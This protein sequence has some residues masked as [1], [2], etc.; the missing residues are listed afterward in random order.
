MKKLNFYFATLLVALLAFS[1]T[2][3]DNPDIPQVEKG[4]RSVEL[5]I[6]RSSTKADDVSVPA[7]TK[8]PIADGAI[9]F[10][11]VDGKCVKMYKLTATD[12]SNLAGNSPT[13]VLIDQVPASASSALLLTNYE[14]ATYTYPTATGQ[15]IT[16]IKALP[17]LVQNQQPKTGNMMVNNVIMSGVA[18]IE[19]NSNPNP[20]PPDALYKIAMTITPI[21]SRLEVSRV[22]VEGNGNQ[23]GDITEFRLR[24]IFIPNFYPASTV[25]GNAVTPPLVYPYN[26]VTY[27]TASFPFTTGTGFLNDYVASTAPHPGLVHQVNTN[28]WA[29]H[30]FP[31]TGVDNLPH[32]VVAVDNI[33]YLDENLIERSWKNGNMKY[34]T[35]TTYNN[36]VGGAPITQFDPSYVY[37][38]EGTDGLAGPGKPGGEGGIIFGL[39][40]LGDKPYTK[41]QSVSCNVTVTAWS[42]TSI[43]PNPL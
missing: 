29:Y 19:T 27:Y 40:D 38:I 41:D 5:K 37:K 3:N 42:V 35:I 13:A 28:M 8:T 16:T 25:Y 23:K 34:I 33:K 9:Y 43:V 14:K 22:G 39:D 31:A 32:I 21:M 20:T 24:G 1:C 17:V 7:G 15:T 6:T 11:A 30:M 36:K 12:I 18:N 26:D 4:E 2:S 10:F